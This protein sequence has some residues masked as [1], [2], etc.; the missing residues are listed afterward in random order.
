MHSSCFKERGMTSQYLQLLSLIILTLI[1]V[2]QVHGFVSNY[3]HRTFMSNFAQFL[4]VP[5]FELYKCPILFP[6]HCSLTIR[7][8]FLSMPNRGC[9]LIL[10]EMRDKP[11]FCTERGPVPPQFL[12]HFDTQAPQQLYWSQSLPKTKLDQRAL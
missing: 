8:T 11:V 6:A 4:F 1:L 2:T 3:V 7:K 10:L 9:L 5:V 12:F